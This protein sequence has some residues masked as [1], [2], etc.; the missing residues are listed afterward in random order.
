VIGARYQG[1]A[2]SQVGL[3]RHDPVPLAL[4]WIRRKNRYMPA[5]A[6]E[7]VTRRGGR[8]TLNQGPAAALGGLVDLDGQFVDLVG[9]D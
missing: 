5:M 8:Q 1:D 6:P 4:E 3:S 2:T 7:T 9:V